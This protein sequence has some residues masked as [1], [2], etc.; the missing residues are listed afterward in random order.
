MSTPKLGDQ[1]TVDVLQA[2][3]VTIPMALLALPG[4]Y[5]AL[6]ANLWD[7]VHS[8]DDWA[9]TNLISALDL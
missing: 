6:D 2:K 5:P 7:R 1:W 4:I 3:Y 9:A 8:A